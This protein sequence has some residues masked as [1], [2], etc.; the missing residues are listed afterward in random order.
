M[1]QDWEALTGISSVVIAL[2]VLVF[3]VWA[4]WRTHVH[5][6]LSVKPHLFT[7]TLM[8]PDEHYYRIQLV[9]NG[10][11]PALIKRFV[12]RL[13]NNVVK[14][15][16][17][18]PLKA[19]IKALF[20]DTEYKVQTAML[21]RDYSLPANE[22]KTIVAIKFFEPCNITPEEFQ[23]RLSRCEL[24]IQYTSFYNDKFTFIHNQNNP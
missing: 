2:C 24:D 1:M 9:N 22:Q 20:L 16:A 11:G 4:G 7:W 23:E 14:G 8:R 18:E 19:V 5:N 17:T 15:K 10:L 13:D 21:N 6:K 3:T 12:V